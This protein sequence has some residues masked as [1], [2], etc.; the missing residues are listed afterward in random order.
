L[1]A[2]AD[3]PD[4]FPADLCTAFLAQVTSAPPA[5]PASL[6]AVYCPED[7]AVYSVLFNEQT[8][9]KIGISTVRK[10][11]GPIF[12]L[13]VSAR[14]PGVLWYERPLHEVQVQQRWPTA[15]V[16]VLPTRHGIE[17]GYGQ[18]A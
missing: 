13:P 6:V 12:R 16:A 10:G 5:N 3:P 14:Q 1:T 15:D 17:D 4:K 7:A 8:D 11:N 9:Q 18:G 2:E